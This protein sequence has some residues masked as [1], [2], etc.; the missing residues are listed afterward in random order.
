[1]IEIIDGTKK[2]LEIAW[3]EPQPEEPES[4][5][6]HNA[7]IIVT[8]IFWL[9]IIVESF[10][11]LVTEYWIIGTVCM[12]AGAVWLSAFLTVNMEWILRRILGQRK[13]R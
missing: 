9:A 12:L 5:K 1:M 10:Y 6:H 11:L 3:W 7:L 13:G 8:A 4:T 2:E